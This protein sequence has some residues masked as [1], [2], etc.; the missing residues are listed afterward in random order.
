MQS[1]WVRSPQWFKVQP[2][3]VSEPEPGSDESEDI[4]LINSQ[5]DSLNDAFNQA[6]AAYYSKYESVNEPAHISEYTP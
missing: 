4:H 6:Q 2:F 3:T 5:R 1:L